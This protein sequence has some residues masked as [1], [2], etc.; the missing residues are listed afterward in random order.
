VDLDLLRQTL[1]ETT[2][3]RAQG[4]VVGVTGLSVR[5]RLA[6]ARIGELIT[7]GRKGEPLLAEIVGFADDEVVAM[8]L[9]EVSG[10]GPD[11][12]VEG[13]GEG[14]RVPSGPALLGRVLDGFG[15]PIDGKPLE[16]GLNWVEATQRPPNAL[17]RRPIARPLVTGVRVVDGFLT[18]GVGQR[19]GLFAGSG[20]G[21]STLLGCIARGLPKEVVVVVA[22]VGERG[23][24]VKEF[25]DECLGDALG[26]AVLVVATS[27]AP[28]L[29]RMKAA[30]T[31]TAIA[32]GFRD[33]GHDVMLLV[34]SVTR[35]AR[36]LREVGL[37]SGEPPARRGYPPTVFAAL[38]RLLER[39]GQG[40]RGSITGLYT[41]L[42]EGGD[43]D[44]PISDEVRG[45]LDGHIVLSRAVAERGTYPA[46]D[47]PASLSRVM[48]RCVD[49]EHDAAAAHA[50]K[51][52][53]AYESRRDLIAMGAYEKGGDAWVDKAILASA[54]LKRFLEQSP[55]EH[56]PI[57]ETKRQLAAI[58][59][60]TPVAAERL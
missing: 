7:V 33:R 35:Y 59:I 41:V 20:V 39:G 49:T 25:I 34:D 57:E 3:L 21:K 56:S 32:E 47:V 51:L 2:S 18:L 58:K 11:D 30:E 4:R 54:E 31:A 38:P 43:M 37:A 45:I 12:A 27:D 36:A 1:A 16:P 19:V 8:P 5:V 23:R 26:R 46:V 28:A 13:S 22:L 50:R 14:L 6:G 52:I 10:I 42:V 40:A 55:H 44:E 48:R 9:G 60:R 53:A 29:E 17:E 15:R 24:E